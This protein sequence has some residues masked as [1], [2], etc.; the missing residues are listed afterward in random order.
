MSYL[1]HN[2]G[3][4]NNWNTE[5]KLTWVEH[6]QVPN[7]GK[8]LQILENQTKSEKTF[9]LYSRYLYNLNLERALHLYLGTY[10]NKCIHVR[11]LTENE[12]VL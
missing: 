4:F 9:V 5:T 6:G 12:A 3:N 2:L 7:N 11:A 10:Y 8:F 1:S